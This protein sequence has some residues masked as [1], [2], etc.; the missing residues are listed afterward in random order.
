MLTLIQFLQVQVLI[1]NFKSY[2]HNLNFVSNIKGACDDGIMVSVMLETL[3][4][5]TQTKREYERNII[6]LFNGAEESPLQ[7]AHG[8]ITQHKW[9]KTCK[10]IINLEAS[11]HGGR[12]IMFQSGPK[13]SSYLLSHYLSVPYPYAQAAGEEIFQSNVIPSDTDFRLFRD[14]GGLSGW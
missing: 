12:A 1:C 3:R 8:F 9:A 14:F 5:L 2:H 13:G 6:F 10:I 4:K 11:G 7:A